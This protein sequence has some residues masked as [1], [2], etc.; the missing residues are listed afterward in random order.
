MGEPYWKATECG[1]E[2]DHVHF[3][4]VNN[5]LVENKQQDGRVSY[6]MSM[7]SK[8]ENKKFPLNATNLGRLSD[9]LGNGEDWTNA[10]FDANIQTVQAPGGKSVL[11]FRVLPQTIQKAKKQTKIS[12]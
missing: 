1:S 12:K 2:G 5:T 11:S 9:K 8:G 4:I 6:A 7:T 3:L 10:E